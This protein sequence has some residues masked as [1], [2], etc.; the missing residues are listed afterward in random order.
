MDQKR[1]ITFTT[2]IN[3]LSDIKLDKQPGHTKKTRLYG[4]KWELFS[5]FIIFEQKLQNN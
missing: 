1:L 4:L 3:V 2:D 5:A